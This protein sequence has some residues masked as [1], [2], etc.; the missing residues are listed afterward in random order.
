MSG[1]FFLGLPA[2]ST[3]PQTLGS[4]DGT[5]HDVSVD[6]TGLTAGT[7]YCADLVATNGSGNGDGG[8]VSFTTT[9]AAVT[10]SLTV[11]LG[12]AGSGSVSGTGIS[13][14]STCSHSYPT[15]TV[16]TLTAA[17]AAGSFFAG[18]SGGGCSGTSSC[19]VTVNSD[20]TITATFNK[21]PNL[22]VSKQGTGTGTVTSSPV[23]IDCG[24]TCVSAF[25]SATVVTLTAVPAAGSRFGGWSGGGCSGS[26]SCAVTLNADTTATAT[27]TLIPPQAKKKAP[28]TKITK[29][30]I[31]AK[32]RMATFKFSGSGGVGKLTFQC[33]LDKKTWASC[34][35]GKTYKNVKRGK[36]T[37]QVRAKRSGMVDKTPATKKFKI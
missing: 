8:Q 28:Q 10:H 6:L 31:N 25:N 19:Q 20:A 12:G 11:S 2:N 37:F 1:A 30:T 3:T 15:G 35:S 29:A 5:F 9:A 34:K 33:K 4:T 17:P 32:K 21:I 13:C 36:H 24:S 26:G 7:S 27:F 22:T 23:G 14:P 16:V 18:W